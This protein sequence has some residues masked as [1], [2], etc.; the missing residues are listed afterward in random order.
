MQGIITQVPSLQ[1]QYDTVP[2]I[3][4]ELKMGLLAAA[5]LLAVASGSVAQSKLVI[6]RIFIIIIIIAVNDPAKAE[7]WFPLFL[8]VSFHSL[9]WEQQ[10]ELIE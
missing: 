5:V 10:L 6:G 8:K 7:L 2:K 4:V 3:E 9:N 1:V